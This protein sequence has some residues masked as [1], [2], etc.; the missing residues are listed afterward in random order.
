[1]VPPKSQDKYWIEVS[2]LSIHD[3]ALWM[4]LGTDPRGHKLRCESDDAY[5]NHYLDHPDG[6]GA[7]YEKCNVLLSAV[8]AGNIKL[9]KTDQTANLIDF[10]NTYIKKDDWIGWCTS[11]G[12]SKPNA[13]FSKGR[14]IPKPIVDNNIKPNKTS[15]TNL[16][17]KSNEIEALNSEVDIEP[18]ITSIV[19]RKKI[20]RNILDSAIDKAIKQAGNEELADV[21]THLKE[22]AIEEMLPFIGKIEGDALLYT[23][24][25]NKIAKLTKDALGKRLRNRK[26]RSK[27]F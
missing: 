10:H 16:D 19:T 4:H 7:V 13:L 24:D 18:T 17:K 1:M 26:K 23:N 14:K 15:K 3:A 12:Y 9:T 11:I 20:G 21:F 22:L 25:H 2:D 6:E 8:R 5:R 27:A